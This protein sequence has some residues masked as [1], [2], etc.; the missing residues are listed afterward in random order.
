[1]SNNEIGKAY[2][3]EKQRTYYHAN[4]AKILQQRKNRRKELSDCLRTTRGLP[5][6]QHH[7]PQP[8]QHREVCETCEAN[9]DDNN[10]NNND[11][12]N[13]DNVSNVSED[14]NIEPPKVL[15]LDNIIKFI[16]Q[17]KNNPS[18]G[19]VFVKNSKS[20]YITSIKTFF[21]ITNCDD[22]RTCLKKPRDIINLVLQGKNK[23]K[24]NNISVNNKKNV[25]QIIL[26][27]ID[28]LN[29]KIDEK[30]KKIYKDEFD[31][32]KIG[33]TDEKEQVQQEDLPTFNYILNKIK[34][35]FNEDSKQYLIAKIYSEFTC[36][37]NLHL[38]I[39][40][41][42]NKTKTLGMKNFLIV[43]TSK[44]DMCRIILNDYKTQAKYGENDYVCSAELSDLLRKYIKNNN[45]VY[46]NYLF[47]EDKLSLIVNKMLSTIGIKG[48][49]SY[50]RRVRV[51]SEIN[52]NNSPEHRLRLS[53]Q[54]GHSNSTQRMYRGTPQKN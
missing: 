18:T 29:I 40:S 21:R 39:V 26:W 41:S 4:R 36:R 7:A 11:D 30:V 2:M 42:K 27:S 6:L 53:E 17:L 16:K 12:N 23:N 35:K 3:A 54:M 25:F 50:L 46:D 9:N 44:N 37:D 49:I 51:T 38:L 10:D 14:E 47:K 19:K 32:M 45:L 34:Q 33:S 13:D 15:S 8:P 1:M 28:N 48:S 5:P 22:L 43:P 31:K 52:K 24:K 20:T